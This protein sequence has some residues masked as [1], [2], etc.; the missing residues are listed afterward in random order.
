MKVKTI[1]RKSDFSRE[2]KGDIFNVS[3]TLDESL[4]PFVKQ[5]EF[6]RALNQAKLSRMFAKP[7]LFQ[8]QGHS[9][10]IY[11]LAKSNSNCNLIASGSFDGEIRI[12]N[13]N[14]QKSEKKHQKSNVKGLEFYRN[15]LY[16][17]GNHE[18]NIY[19]DGN[20]VQII[21]EN[22]LNSISHHF[23]RDLFCTSSSCLELWDSTRQESFQSMQWGCETIDKVKFNNSEQNVLLSCGSDR[24]II[25][26]DIRTSTPITKT[27]M[28]LKT[29]SLCWNPMEPFNFTTASEDHNCYS[30][31]MRYMN[32][33]LCVH[34]G[35]VSAVLD[36]DYSP[37][38]QEFVTG[39]FDKT[40]RIFDSRGGKSKDIYHTKRMQR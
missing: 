20:T 18:I 3:K 34:K 39:S 16:S 25:L 17:I 36:I 10:S 4:H 21:T 11:S 8:L 32:N 1:S 13:V 35:H 33:T 38:G 7:F 26:Y 29:N 27:I 40:I 31:D 24:S 6:T 15:D 23:S 37:T 30:F 22:I 28:N 9:D 19:K 2:R 5:R 14:S 12:W